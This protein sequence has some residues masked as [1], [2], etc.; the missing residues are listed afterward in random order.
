MGKL[1]KAI[2]AAFCGAFLVGGAAT[3]IISHVEKSNSQ[4]EID[5][6]LQSYDYSEGNTNLSQEEFVESNFSDVDKQN[7]ENLV[8]KQQNW[9]RYGDALGGAALVAGVV[10]TAGVTTG[11]ALERN[12]I[13]ASEFLAEIV[14]SLHKSEYGENSFFEFK[15]EKTENSKPAEEN[16]LQK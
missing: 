8:A 5:K 2:V 10:A 11:Y 7:Y 14:N 1:K 12:G 6:I 9:Q 15:S 4:N 3:L 13:S 16:K